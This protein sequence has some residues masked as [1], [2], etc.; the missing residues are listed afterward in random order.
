MGRLADRFGIV[1]PVVIG[2][3][4][5]GARLLSGVAGRQAWQLRAGARG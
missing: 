2:A 3:L 4:M 1:V 5:L